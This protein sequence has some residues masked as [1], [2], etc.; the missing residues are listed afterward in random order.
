M[1]E[2]NVLEPQYVP[3]EKVRIPFLDVS[4][5]LAETQENYLMFLLNL[6]RY[7]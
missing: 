5:S 4:G 6:H 3:F 7:Y 1:G 2:N